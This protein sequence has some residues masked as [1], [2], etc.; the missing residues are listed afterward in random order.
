[1]TLRWARTF[2][3]QDITTCCVSLP[4]TIDSALLQTCQTS[5]LKNSQKQLENVQPNGVPKGNCMAECI[6]NRTQIYR[7]NGIIDRN[8]LLRIFLNSVIG[9]REWEGIVTNTVNMCINE[10]KSTSLRS[11][12]A[13]II[14]FAAR[15]KANE[16]R[17]GAMMKGSFPGEV[18]CHP[19][20]G[21]LLGCMNTE[22][23]YRCP[24]MTSSVE[25]DGLRE[26]ASS[27]HI[28]VKYD[29]ANKIEPKV[30]TRRGCFTAKNR[31]SDRI[32]IANYSSSAE[33]SSSATRWVAFSL[34]W[35][36]MDACKHLTLERW[37]TKS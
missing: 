33:R 19:I 3:S 10:S 8:S 37:L 36:V 32:K 35:C 14:H 24:N 29:W 11:L 6:A 9:L 27:C 7:G 4:N 16:L 28:P 26:Y 13:L 31:L 21:Y 2:H 22:L 1:M 12:F 34:L 18:I 15:V 5:F 23:F 30:T 25:C 20:S 17:E